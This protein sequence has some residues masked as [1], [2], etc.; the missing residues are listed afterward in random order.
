MLACSS[1]CV[2]VTFTRGSPTLGHLTNLCRNFCEFF[3]SENSLKF[4]NFFAEVRN[5]R[6]MVE[7]PTS[8]RRRK[9]TGV[10]LYGYHIVLLPGST[11]T[12]TP[13]NGRTLFFRF[14]FTRPSLPELL[15]AKSP[16]SEFLLFK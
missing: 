10:V 2:T 11:A 7:A 5:S 8:G 16:R 4:G 13:G 3:I 14:S 9:I 15:K 12:T 1:C 6:S